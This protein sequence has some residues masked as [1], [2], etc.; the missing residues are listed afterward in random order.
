M[1]IYDLKQERKNTLGKIL[2]DCSFLYIA[3]LTI[4]YVQHKKYRIIIRNCLIHRNVILRS[5]EKNGRLTLR[6]IQK[7]WN[8]D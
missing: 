5:R 2:S 3:A 6:I 7:L 4:P 1:R 8:I